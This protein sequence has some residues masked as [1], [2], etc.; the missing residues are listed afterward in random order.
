MA[1]TKT[2]AE[3]MFDN[4]KDRE[5]QVVPFDE[6]ISELELIQETFLQASG[7]KIPILLNPGL[8]GEKILSILKIQQPTPDAIECVH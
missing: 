4:K 5:N 6:I 2:K 3:I 7:I 1:E 8:L